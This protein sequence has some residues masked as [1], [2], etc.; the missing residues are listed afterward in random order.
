MER[1]FNLI[2]IKLYILENLIKGLSMD[3]DLNYS[4]IKIFIWEIENKEKFLV[5]EF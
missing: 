1:D 3:K 4:Q 5:K 2:Q